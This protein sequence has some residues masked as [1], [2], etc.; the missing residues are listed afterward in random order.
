[1]ALLVYIAGTRFSGDSRALQ[2]IVNE[3]SCKV[4]FS[5]Q[6]H[7]VCQIDLLPVGV[8]HISMLVRPSGRAVNASGEGLFLS[9]D[10]RLDAVE[11]ARAAETGNT[12]RTPH[13]L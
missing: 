13:G 10:P 9:V 7:V 5:N 3:T 8:H 11:P 6:T 12:G 1:M 2:I 4:I